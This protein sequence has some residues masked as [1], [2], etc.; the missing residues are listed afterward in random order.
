MQA[1]SGAA[2]S[3]SDHVGAA[4]SSA[5]SATKRCARHSRGPA[6]GCVSPSRRTCAQSSELGRHAGASPGRRRLPSS[7]TSSVATRGVQGLEWAACPHSAPPPGPGAP[8][9]AFL[10]PDCLDD[11][12]MPGSLR[13]PCTVHPEVKPSRDPGEDQVPRPEQGKG[14]VTPETPGPAA[15]A[16]SSPLHPR[17]GQGAAAAGA[18]GS[19]CSWCPKGLLGNLQ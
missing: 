19:L 16:R 4:V 5:S 2:P 15:P 11:V 8:L 17:P 1:G 3:Q 14:G 12:S 18:L 9:G 10:P 7:P 13:G 6:E